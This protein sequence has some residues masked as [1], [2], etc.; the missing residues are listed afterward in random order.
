MSTI[1]SD[2]SAQPLTGR[3]RMELLCDSF[4]ALRGRP[5]TSPWDAETFAKYL[6]GPAPTSASLQAGLFVLSVWNGGNGGWRP[7]SREWWT[8]KP[9][10]LGMFDLVRAWAQWDHLHKQAFLAWCDDPFYP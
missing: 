8:Q 2:R 6:A 1:T 5:G 10:F 3:Q 9:Y 7:K 4:H